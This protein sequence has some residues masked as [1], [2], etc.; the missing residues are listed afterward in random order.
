[1]GDRKD[2]CPEDKEAVSQESRQRKPWT[3]LVCSTH[4]SFCGLPP[5]MIHVKVSRFS[6]SQERGSHKHLLLEMK[7]GKMMCSG[8]GSR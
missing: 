8:H 4:S 6:N 7:G 5:F 3:P 1:M 2:R